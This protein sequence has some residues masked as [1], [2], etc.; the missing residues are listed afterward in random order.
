MV[1]KDKAGLILAE[2]FYSDLITFKV[3]CHKV[4][5][6]DY[7]QE[8]SEKNVRLFR[9]DVLL[10]RNCYNLV[11]ALI[12]NFYLHVFSVPVFIILISSVSDNIIQQNLIFVNKKKVLH[13]TDA[14]KAKRR[15]SSAVALFRYVYLR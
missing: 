3:G 14:E 6:R 13:Y 4:G 9:T 12:F 1:H 15:Q 8:G 10:F 2:L 5:L 11:I 7:L